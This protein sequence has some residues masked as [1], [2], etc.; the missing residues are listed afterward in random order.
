MRLA[1]SFSER[2]NTY[3]S[4]NPKSLVLVFIQGF[5]LIYLFL[6]G[7]VLPNHTLAGILELIGLVIGFW[8]I[9]AM[10]ITTIQITADVAPDGNLV[11]DG[12]YEF[13]R[14]PM[15]LAVMLVGL[16]LILN[17]PDTMRIIAYC[18]LGIDFIIK[19]NYEEILLVKHFKKGYEDYQKKTKK[20]IP[21][22]Y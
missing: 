8:S 15:Y 22:I 6:S 3:V 10:R 2:H 4:T 9:W 5:L 16:G 12:P 1:L 13:V 20:F 19:A 11:S 17:S 7:P 18:L 14:H 21:F